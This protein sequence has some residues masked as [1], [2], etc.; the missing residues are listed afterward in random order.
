MTER[1]SVGIT[2]YNA[3]DT[4][5]SAVRSALCQ[6]WPNTEILVVDD[7]SRDNSADL[8]AE[9]AA[10]A[11]SVRLIRRETNGGPGAAR[12]TLLE[13]ATGDYIA[14]FDDDDVSAPNR[15]SAQHARLTDWQRT[16][17]D[18]PAVCYA[19]GTRR[20]PNGHVLTLDAIGSRPVVPRGPVVADYLLFGARPDGYFF[21]A[22]TPTCALMAPR[23]VLESAGGF[24]PA[25]RRV[26]DA[27]LAV[28]LALAGAAFVGTQDYLFEQHATFADDKSAAR[29]YEAELYLVEKHRGYLQSR[30][31]YD[32]ARRWFTVRYRHFSGDRPGLLWALAGLCL[33]HPVT[34]TAHLCRAAP[35]RLRHE[36]RADLRRR[37]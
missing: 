15:L 9:L 34:A 31:R 12:Q 17:G 24:D 21:G 23:R 20:Y 18:G 29:N 3:A 30:G 4:I 10:E 1:I 25:M 37:G 5:V 22:G 8:V 19:S 2:C 11:P 36:R 28:R 35:R 7:A 6:D 16:E 33:R 14:F 27:D 13:N 32:Y 26:E